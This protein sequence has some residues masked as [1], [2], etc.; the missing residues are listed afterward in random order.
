M[1]PNAQSGGRGGG[2]THERYNRTDLQ[3]A[4][5]DHLDTLPINLK[6]LLYVEGYGA[7]AFFCRIWSFFEQIFFKRKPPFPKS[8]AAAQSRPGAAGRG[9]LEA[10]TLGNAKKCEKRKI[11]RAR[12]KF[13]ART[14][15][16]PQLNFAPAVEGYRG[17][18]L[19]LFAGCGVFLNRFF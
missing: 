9:N 19:K 14:G 5:F 2:R 15:K 12:Q 16:N 3:S 8:P 1:Q 7:Q 13:R 10:E 4:S 6:P 17:T 11:N 18:A